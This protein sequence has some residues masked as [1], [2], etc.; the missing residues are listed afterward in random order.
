MVSRVVDSVKMNIEKEGKVG[1]GFHASARL[2][3]LHYRSD[4]HFRLVSTLLAPHR[5]FC[6]HSDLILRAS[7]ARGSAPSPRTLQRHLGLP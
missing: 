7:L 5:R 4:C 1:T 3:L 2:S 6:G